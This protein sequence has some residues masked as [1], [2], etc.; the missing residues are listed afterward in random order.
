MI[1]SLTMTAGE[2]GCSGDGIQHYRL[3]I[4]LQTLRGNARR[5]LEYQ[6]R[7]NMTKTITKDAKP[8]LQVNLRN[9]RK[10]IKKIRPLLN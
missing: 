4:I 8:N 10:I 9:S 7:V 5:H 6:T 2:E 1:D 3:H